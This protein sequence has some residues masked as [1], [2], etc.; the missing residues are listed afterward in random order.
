MIG[1]QASEHSSV[2]HRP[3]DC[4]NIKVRKDLHTSGLV[5]LQLRPDAG[6]NNLGQAAW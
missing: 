5:R 3:V 6:L 4:H 2:H 1:I